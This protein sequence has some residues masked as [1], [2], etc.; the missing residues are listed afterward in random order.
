MSLFLNPLVMLLLLLLWL[1]LLLLFNACSMKNDDDFCCCCC[2]C[3]NCW[4][5]CWL[6][7]WKWFCC[8]CCCRCRRAL[9]RWLLIFGCVLWKSGDDEEVVDGEGVGVGGGAIGEAPHVWIFSNGFLKLFVSPAAPVPFEGNDPY[10]RN[11][12]STFIYLYIIDVN[13]VTHTH[14]FEY[15]LGILFFYFLCL[16]HQLLLIYS[17]RIIWIIFF[18][19]YL[20]DIIHTCNKLSFLEQ[21]YHVLYLRISL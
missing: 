6:C 13:K 18:S 20:Y 1:L 10:A 12:I 16:F 14:T 4:W 8:W 9:C 19:F 15:L 7:A 21:S 3:C 5:C 11:M 17:V 2:C